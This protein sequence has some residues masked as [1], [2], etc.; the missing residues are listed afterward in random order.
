MNSTKQRRNTPQR[1]VVLEELRA[2]ESHPTAAELFSVVRGKLPRISLG[3]VYRNLEV[4]Y[5]DGLINKLELA[6]SET[7]FDGMTEPHLHIRCTSCGKVQDVMV[8]ALQPQTPVELV[9]FQVQGCRTEYFG[10]CPDCRN[11]PRH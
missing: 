3:T 10:V 11:L 9:G 7:R 4:L 6:G 8:P 5:E 1:H 2:M